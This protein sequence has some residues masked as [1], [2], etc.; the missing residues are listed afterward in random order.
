MAKK[1]KDQDKTAGMTDEAVIAAM[2]GN[3]PTA[4]GGAKPKGKDREKVQMDAG[5]ETFIALQ[6]VSDSIDAVKEQ[7]EKQYKHGV[8][9]D[10]FY[11]FL[12]KYK[13]KPEAFDAFFKDATCQFQFRRKASI[14]PDAEFPALQKSLVEVLVEN[15]IPFEKKESVPE[16]LVI[17]PLILE[18]QGALAKLSRALMN[19]DLGFQAIQK[20]EPVYKYTFTD[21]AFK[22]VA[23]VKDETTRQ[24][25]MRAMSTPACSQPKLGGLDETDG[26]CL[27]RALKILS[28]AKILETAKDLPKKKKYTRKDEE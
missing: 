25:L 27:A 6:L 13:S 20:Q 4:P 15:A 3:L 24:E 22:A 21:A 12:N 26:N 1:G 16:R 23:E 10:E 14:K 17:N 7:Q 2:M 8:A 11:K 5:F 28:D 18:D 9:M 19:L